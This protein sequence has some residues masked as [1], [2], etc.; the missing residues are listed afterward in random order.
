MSRGSVVA[1]KYIVLESIGEG[2]R[3]ATYACRCLHD[4][5][6]LVALKMLLP[7]AAHDAGAVAA[8]AQEYRLAKLIDHPHVL[9]VYDWIDL[10]D[11]V[12]Y[13]LE[14]ALCG[15]LAEVLPEGRS[16]SVPEIETLG[17][18]MCTALEAV[19][20][21]GLV[22]NNF[23]LHSVYVMKD[24]RLKLGGFGPALAPASGKTV[25]EDR[26]HG[27]LD[28]VSP[29]Y[30]R[31]GTI[32]AASDV[33]ALGIVLYELTTGRYPFER[34][35]SPVE[36]LRHRLSTDAPAPVYCRAACPAPLNRVIIN[37]MR[38]EWQNRLS[39]IAEV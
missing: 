8:F 16:L 10:G 17:R 27:H 7:H 22:H 3:S 13:T 9:Q 37:A 15:T 19:H 11:S 35:S 28:Y 32:H 31:N 4:A 39:S 25:R 34:L 2:E 33:Y 21:A 6:Q 30:V 5:G 14:Y 29:E 20:R 23:G 38:R 1:G 18:Q 24:G 26:I 36:S 12:A